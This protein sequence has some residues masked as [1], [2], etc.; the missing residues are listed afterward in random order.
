VQDPPPSQLFYLDALYYI[1]FFL[2]S[3][4][5]YFYPEIFIHVFI[6]S[7]IVINTSVVCIDFCVLAEELYSRAMNLNKLQINGVIDYMNR[8]GEVVLLLFW[9]QRLQA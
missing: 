3:L 8:T 9:S 7:K 4:D 1:L 5:I 2:Q 6:F